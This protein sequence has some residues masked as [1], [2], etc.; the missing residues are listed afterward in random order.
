VQQSLASEATTAEKSFADVEVTILGRHGGTSW[1]AEVAVARSMAK[2]RRIILRTNQMEFGARP[3][4]RI[5]I[6]G[7]HVGEGEDGAIM[8][9]LVTMGTMS[10]AYVAS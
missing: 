3:G 9:A 6:L 8:P 4:D 7:A 1:D 5:R 2:G 10:E